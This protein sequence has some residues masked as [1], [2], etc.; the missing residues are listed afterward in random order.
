MITVN[1]TNLTKTFNFLVVDTFYYML[2]RKSS[3]TEFCLWASRLVDTYVKAEAE[4][5]GLITAAKRFI[6]VWTTFGSKIYKALKQIRMPDA[7]SELT[8][9]SLVVC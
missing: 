6:L 9:L 8:M 5:I 2:Q 3:V 4:R 7:T 1:W